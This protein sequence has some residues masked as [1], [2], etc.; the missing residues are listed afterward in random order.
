[1]KNTKVQ[2]ETKVKILSPVSFEEQSIMYTAI[3]S[4]KGQKPFGIEDWKSKEG[5][6]DTVIGNSEKN[7]EGGYKLAGQ[8]KMVFTISEHEELMSDLKAPIF[9]SLLGAKLAAELVEKLKNCETETLS[10]EPTR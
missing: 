4:P 5:L 3:V 7:N 6:Y 10:P 9:G 8:E 2:T 1:M